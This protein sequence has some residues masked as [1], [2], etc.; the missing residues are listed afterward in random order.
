MMAENDKIAILTW[1]QKGKREYDRQKAEEKA[2]E[3]GEELPHG[4]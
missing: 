2:E 3:K 1:Y 4:D